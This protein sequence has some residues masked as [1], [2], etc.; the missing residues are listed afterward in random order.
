V[1]KALIPITITTLVTVAGVVAHAVPVAADPPGHRPVEVSHGRFGTL[2]DGADLGY[3]IRGRA[4]MFR[5]DADGG[6]TYVSIRVR[7]LDPDTTY[8]THV[9][10]LPCSSTPAGGGHYQHE[11][12]GAVDGA[13]E[14]WPTISTTSRGHGAGSAV[15]GERAREDARSVVIH[16]PENSAIRLACLDLS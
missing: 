8:K 4:V 5:T 14:I 13:N 16:W 9:H 2:P 6:T 11:I 7:G 3:D 10:D 1:N 12:G 15:H